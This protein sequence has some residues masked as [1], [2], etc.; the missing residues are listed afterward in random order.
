MSQE[1]KQISKSIQLGQRQSIQSHSFSSLEYH[2]THLGI[3]RFDYFIVCYY[4][5]GDIFL[6]VMTVIVSHCEQ[7]GAMSAKLGDTSV[8]M[9]IDPPVTEAYIPPASASALIASA[10]STSPPR[11]PSPSFS[12]EPEA[13]NSSSSPYI[14]PSS[15]SN[16]ISVNTNTHSPPTQQIVTKEELKFEMTLPSAI[17][18]TTSSSTPAAKNASM[19]IESPPLRSP[20]LSSSSFSSSNYSLVYGSEGTISSSDTMQDIDS[21]TTPSTS[22]SHIIDP[23]IPAK[24]PMENINRFWMVNVYGKRS[25]NNIWIIW[26][27]MWAV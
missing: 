24:I 20:P 25:I 9:T 22:I 4:M 11:S 7:D 15:L 18:T 1:G 2:I 3:S 6:A 16:S 17:L 19:D 5:C 12:P 23:T 21:V 26:W 27:C 10:S 14:S 13:S 8:P